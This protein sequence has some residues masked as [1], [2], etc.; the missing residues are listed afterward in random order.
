MS[1]TTTTITT[2]ENNIDSTSNGTTTNN[3]HYN[4]LVVTQHGL[5][6]G[7]TDFN[8]IRDRLIEK[9]ENKGVIVVATHK[10]IDKCG[11][12]AA[13]E[14]EDLCE[15]YQP[16]IITFIGHSLGGLILRFAIGVLYKKG[17]FDKVMPDQYISL[18]SP[19]CGSRRPKTTLFNKL[20]N[21]VCDTFLSVTG[22]QLM[23]S[24]NEKN[25]EDDETKK[26]MEGYNVD[27]KTPLLVQMSEGLFLDGLA[28]FRR[29][30]LYS[31]IIKDFQ[32]NFCTSDIV[33]RN[34][35]TKGLKQLRFSEQ[36]PHVID[37]P[38]A[39]RLQER[40]ETLLEEDYDKFFLN[41]DKGV[42]LRRI[43]KNLQ[44]L[45]YKRYHLYFT[46]SLAHTH[47]IIK[48]EML[49]KKD[50]LDV[51]NHIIDHFEP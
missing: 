44:K 9:Y 43:V 2:Q 19:H 1:T 29:R 35:Y 4:H 24:D 50:G 10:G 15:K 18:S 22:N 37:D 49:N 16:T 20:A 12:L 25:F 39:D 8:F 26:M 38:D 14:I 21:S 48:R 3:K 13:E 45:Q 33:H 47:I 42:Y 17:F 36:Y 40:D 28:K 34:P 31:N 30:V 41:D 7:K 51:V 5:H 32:V 46:D 27:V 11:I 6:G 23:L